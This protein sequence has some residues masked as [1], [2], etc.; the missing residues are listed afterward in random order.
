MQLHAG[1]LQPL[2]ITAC[3]G[4][5]L[6]SGVGMPELHVSAHTMLCKQNALQAAGPVQQ[7]ALC[8]AISGKF[9]HVLCSRASLCCR[10]LLEASPVVT[11]WVTGP[12]GCR[13][14]CCEGQTRHDQQLYGQQ[15]YTGS[16]HLVCEAVCHS[17]CVAMEKKGVTASGW[18]WLPG[19][20]QC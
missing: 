11:V 6:W 10:S 7:V 4:V 12:R 19:A 18:A 13:T 17:C 8:P 5:A 20:C 15:V 14:I 2:Y 1:L 9:W 16:G 3:S